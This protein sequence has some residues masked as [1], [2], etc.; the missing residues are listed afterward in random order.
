MIVKRLFKGTREYLSN[1]ST[2]QPVFTPALIIPRDVYHSREMHI[3]NHT[4]DR[5]TLYCGRNDSV[6]S[7]LYDDPRSSDFTRSRPTPAEDSAY[8][9][10]SLSVRVITCE[11]SVVVHAVDCEVSVRS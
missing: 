4:P 1:C 10:A 11:Y 2:S 9:P 6:N 3:D 5:D 8:I 7:E